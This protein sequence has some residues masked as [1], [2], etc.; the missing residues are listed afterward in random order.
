MTDPKEHPEPE[1]DP[2]ATEE[3][4]ARAQV[5]EEEEVQLQEGFSIFIIP[6]KIQ[7]RFCRIMNFGSIMFLVGLEAKVE[8]V[9]LVI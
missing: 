7:D 1:L 4:L 2:Q 5:L 6:L 3:E 9:I 8:T